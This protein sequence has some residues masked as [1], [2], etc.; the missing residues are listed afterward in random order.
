MSRPRRTRD[1]LRTLVLEAG[2]AIVDEEGLQTESG[3]LTFKRVFDRLENRTGERI[4]NASVIRRV[5]ENQAEFQTDVLVAVA[6]DNARPEIGNTIDALGEVIAGL[7]LS[8][9]A[10]RSQGVSDVCRVGGNAMTAVITESTSWSLWISVVALASGSTDPGQQ[11]RIKDALTGSYDASSSFWHDT[12]GA[13]ASS[14]GLRFRP[15]YTLQQFVM[16]VT[17]YSEGCAMRQ[18]TTD[19]VEYIARP[20]GPDGTDQEWSLFAVGLEGL[21][22]QFLEPDPAAHG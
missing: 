3:N 12:L 9:V 4:T 13:L 8:T 1:E 22:H 20:T 19:H 5:W 14:F 2:R 16:A 15:Q 17:A 6:N 7:D 21:V 11:Q 10:S 18:R